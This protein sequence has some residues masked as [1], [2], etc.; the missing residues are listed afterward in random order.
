MPVAAQTAN[1]YHPVLGQLSF[2]GDATGTFSPADTN[3]FFNYSDYDENPLRSIQGRLIAQWTLTTSVSLLGEL[4][5][6]NGVGVDGAAW[7]MRWHPWANRQFD[8]QVGRIPPVIG[9]FARQPYAR[10]NPLIDAP[11]A[12]QYLMSLRPDALP[13]T[14]DD[15]IRMRGRGW[16]PAFPVGSTTVATGIPIVSAFRWD[17]GGEVHWHAGRTDL[18]GAVTRGSM[19]VPAVGTDV[20]G[21]VTVS[22]RLAMDGPGGLTFG[23]SGARG[24]WIQ[25]STLALVPATLQNDNSQTLIGADFQFGWGRWLVR[26]EELRSVFTLPLDKA[27]NPTTH[28]AVWSGYVE[29]RYRFLPQW[30]VAARVENLN[31]SSIAGTLN[32]GLPISWEAPVERV[33]L[34]VDYRVDR[35]VEIRAGG[36]M[37]WRDGGRILKR[38]YPAVQLLFWF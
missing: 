19:A 6:E 27:T 38:A 33:S 36:Q 17:T 25:S 22:G 28:L 14:A 13:A 3:A 37:N 1:T 34:D 35:Q 24:P 21:G 4:L 30:Q 16:Q 23:V 8:I 9:L 7:Y 2:A 10:D 26:A 18:A 12:Y 29:G 11:L 5:A 20:N 32:G 15:L 31:F